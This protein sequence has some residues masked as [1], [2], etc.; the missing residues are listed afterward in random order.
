ML[1]ELGRAAMADLQ[2][3]AA[4][5]SADGTGNGLETV[6]LG[7]G[8]HYQYLEPGQPFPSARPRGLLPVPAQVAAFVAREEARI[9]GEHGV[10][11]S[12]ETKRRMLNEGTLDAYYR[13]EWVSYRETL[14]GVE[15][16][17]VGLD[18]IGRLPKQPVSGDQPL[19]RTRQI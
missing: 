19:I 11:L 8:S 12:E 17:A 16:L 9:L 6:T 3:Q 1:N 4:S 15:V 13:Y 2:K 7:L 18:E 10:Q 5:A 14:E